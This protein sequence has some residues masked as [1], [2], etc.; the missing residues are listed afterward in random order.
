M[1]IVFDTFEGQNLEIADSSWSLYTILSLFPLPHIVGAVVPLD[2]DE[3]HVEVTK[4]AI[5]E[6]VFMA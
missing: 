4:E 2:C 1:R 3:H 5:Q 6:M